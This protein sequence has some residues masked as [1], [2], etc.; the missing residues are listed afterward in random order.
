[1]SDREQID[2]NDADRRSG[3][4]V[5]SVDRA[6]LVLEILAAQGSAGITEI[7]DELGV[8]KSTVSRLV[9]VLEKRGFVEQLSDRGKYRLGFTVVR[10]A[11]ATVAGQDLSKASQARCDALAEEV[12]ETVNLA[13]LEGDRAINIVEAAG[14]AGVSLRTWVG[15][16]SPAHATSSG[17]MLISELT[18]QELRERLGA[19]LEKYTDNTIT[20]YSALERNLAQAREQGWI[21]AVAELETGLHAL[22][23]PVRDHTSK[24]VGALTISGPAY[25]MPADRFDD[26]AARAVDVGAEIS[27][28]LGYLPR[29]SRR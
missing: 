23:A 13:I 29:L 20:T 9:G 19:R 27:A 5:Q 15:Q 1:M 8:H 11:G 3:A 16:A 21:V 6:L 22:A 12:G 14:A 25:R 28:R 17:K 18:S 26:L 2:G 24:I 4:A 7:A 10:L